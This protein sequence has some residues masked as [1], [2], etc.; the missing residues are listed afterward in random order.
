MTDWRAR[1]ACIDRGEWHLPHH[2]NA[3]AETVRISRAA[4]AI[5]VCEGC[6]VRAQCASLALESDVRGGIWAGV[7][8]GDT[9]HPVSMNEAAVRQLKSVA[10]V[11]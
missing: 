7:D 1:A 6:P 5:R 4:E 11:A 9:S 8:L 2:R 3:A 10:G